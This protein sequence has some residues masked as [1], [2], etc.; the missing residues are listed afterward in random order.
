MYFGVGWVELVV[1]FSQ[2]NYD[3]VGFE[4]DKIIVVLIYNYWDLVIGI[5]G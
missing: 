2:V 1:F 3:G 4:Y 5:Y